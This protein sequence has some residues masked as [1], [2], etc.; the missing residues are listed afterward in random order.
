MCSSQTTAVW[1]T[2][3]CITHLTQRQVRHR[4]LSNHLEQRTDPI[5]P[6]LPNLPY[7]ILASLGGDSILG[8]TLAHITPVQASTHPV[9]LY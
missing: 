5:Y 6:N 9:E 8:V 1:S 3:R 4:Y 7:K 2:L